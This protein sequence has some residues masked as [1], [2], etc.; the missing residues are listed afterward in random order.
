V[1]KLHY[2][3]TKVYVEVVITIKLQ[4]TWVLAVAKGVLDV[5]LSVA[6]SVVLSLL[7]ISG[8][9]E[10]NPGPVGGISNF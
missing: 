7:L 2:V 4:G 10:E 8:D 6:A 9:V 1:E 3:D 5:A